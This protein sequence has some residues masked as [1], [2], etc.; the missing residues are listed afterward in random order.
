MGACGC[1]AQMAGQTGSI[2]NEIFKGASLG[3]A[4]GGIGG[5][6]A[7]L[8]A[9]G[10]AAVGTLGVFGSGAGLYSAGRDISQEGLNFCN[11]TTA[12][13]SAAG[14]YLSGGLAKRGYSQLIDDAVFGL[15]GFR[16]P[17]EFLP[18]S[19]TGAWRNWDIVDQVRGG[20]AT[21]PELPANIAETF[22][23]GQYMGK[24]YEHG[25]NAYR[26]EGDRFGRW[27]GST[28]PDSAA[29]AERSYNVAA[30]GNDLVEV[31]TY[32]IPQRTLI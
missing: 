24:V 12:A 19:R 28:K 17:D 8:G 15:S 11:F 29:N 23:G 6:I 3:L 30:Y 16:V 5:G 31:S 21:A 13:A 18:P 4:G 2:G 25:L 9:G 1:E 32:R 10:Q 14:L 26:A 20:Y 7:G 22:E 27:Y